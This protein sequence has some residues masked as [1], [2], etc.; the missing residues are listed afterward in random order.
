MGTELTGKVLGLIGAGN[1]GSI[2]ADRAQGLHMR[3]VAYDP[4][5]S[6]KRAL[7][8][9][10]E[11][12]ELAELLARA[13]FITLHTPLTDATRNIVS[14]EN[15][16]KCKKGVRI[17]NCARG[18]LIDEAALAAALTSGQVGGA[19]LDVFE[20]EPARDS[21]LFAFENVVCTPHLGASTNEAQE[22][23]WHSRLPSRSAS[24]S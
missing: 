23:T 3:V 11:K 9:G 7:D 12:L 5:L 10:V 18:G 22:R 24:F 13:D 1:I 20:S 21:P 14:S 17:I 2:V 4:Y 15:L 19:A 6:E 8:M 16:R